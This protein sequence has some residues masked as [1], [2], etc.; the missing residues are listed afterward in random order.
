MKLIKLIFV[1]LSG[2]LFD[3]GPVQG[4]GKQGGLVIQFDDGWTSWATLIAPELKKVGGVATGFVNNQNLRSGRI[5][6]EDLL[7]LQNTYGWEIGSHTWHHLNAPAFVRKNGIDR[8]LNEELNQSQ[9]ELRA[10]GLTIHSLVFPFNLFDKKLSEA[11]QPRVETY[12]RAE[13][14]ALTTGVSADKSVPGTA[15]DM[16]HYVPIDLLKQW[17]DMAA[18]RNKLLFLYG[19]RILP[20]SHFATG[21]V[22]S[23]TSTTLTAAVSVTLPSGT[24]L[25]LAPDLTRRTGTDFFNVIQVTGA[26]IEVDRADLSALTQP[27]AQFLIGEAYSTRL[28]DFRSLVEYAATK[29][30]FYTLHDIASGKHLAPYKLLPNAK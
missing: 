21:T 17:I 8:W 23:V 30:N 18:E 27:G 12:R 11:I 10:A 26:V 1:A 24:D 2:L 22:V 14:F 3:A 28:S 7:T 15:I 16:A 5:T 20:D 9:S 29:V 19:H 6:L 13:R 25:V 4:A